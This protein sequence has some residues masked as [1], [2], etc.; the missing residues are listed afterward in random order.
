MTG[1]TPL[2]RLTAWLRPQY[3][4]RCGHPRLVHQHDR[5]SIE[6]SLCACGRFRGDRAKL[7]VRA[8]ASR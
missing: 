8:R 4:I 3:C 6:C 1:A 7:A 2:A 5:H